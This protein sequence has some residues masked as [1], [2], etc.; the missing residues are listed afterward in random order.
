[1]RQRLLTAGAG[2]LLTLL[3]GCGGGGGGGGSAAPPP[4]P[5]PVNE[6]PTVLGTNTAAYERYVA[7][8]GRALTSV[9]DDGNFADLAVL[10]PHLAGRRIV[11]LGESTHGAREMNQVKTRLIKYLHQQHGF[12][13]LV[14]ESGLFSCTRGLEQAEI[15]AA[16]LMR[17]CTFGVWWTH[18]VVELFRY[19]L[20]TQATDRPL[21]LA[22]MDVQFSGN[23]DDAMRLRHWLD[24]QLALQPPPPGLPATADWHAAVDQM[25]QLQPLL[26]ACWAG[27]ATQCQAVL[28]DHA[29]PLAV[30]QA[31]ADA[32]T[33]ADDASPERWLLAL[34]A[35]NLPMILRR[36]AENAGGYNGSHGL[37][38]R[39]MADNLTALAR[40]VYPESRL[41]VWAHNAHTI[42]DHYGDASRNADDRPTGMHLA[43]TWGD[44]LYSLGLFMLSGVSGNTSSGALET[45]AVTPHWADSLEALAASV[46]HEL[47]FLPFTRSD[48]PGPEDD[49]LHRLTLAKNWGAWDTRIFPSR[50]FNAVITLRRTSLP[51]YL[52]FLD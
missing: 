36:M 21:R 47:M 28:A 26:Q 16:V 24:V 27:N 44:E 41:M 35:R 7:Q 37:R 52:H 13:V 29:A 10:D 23:E 32:L 15:A 1:M 34:Q 43:E 31:F 4:S 30:L 8:Q 45:V 39:Y 40:H 5:P 6:G 12:D 9:T 51:A 17:S 42:T 11:L 2:V 3:L 38:D 20:A 49:W 25:F 48:E 46:P 19:V 14:F 50:S 18:E 33:P 22:G